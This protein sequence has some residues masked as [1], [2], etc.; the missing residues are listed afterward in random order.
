M[1]ISNLLLCV[2]NLLPAICDNAEQLLG[3]CLQSH[4]KI[5]RDIHVKCQELLL[6]LIVR[7]S[8]L[9]IL[10]KVNETVDCRL[11]IVTFS[12]GST[13]KMVVKGRQV[14]SFY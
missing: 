3:F 9:D 10:Y 4:S 1:D 12:S 6:C 14:K 7:G 13:S 2:A 5:L 8:S 11:L